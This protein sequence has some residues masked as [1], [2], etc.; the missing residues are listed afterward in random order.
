MV[1]VGAT[2]GADIDLLGHQLLGDPLQLGLVD[3]VN[4]GR[5]D[6]KGDVVKFK[7]PAG[8]PGADAFV[9][10]PALVAPLVLRLAGSKLA[11]VADLLVCQL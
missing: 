3:F 2:G 8:V 6:G 1:A 5:T 10:L 7:G 4:V 9:A 11:A